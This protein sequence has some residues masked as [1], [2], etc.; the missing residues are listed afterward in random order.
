MSPLSRVILSEKTRKEAGVYLANP[1]HALLVVGSEGDG[2]EKLSNALV[3]EIL[4]IDSLVTL[5]N[6]PRAMVI[7]PNKNGNI[8]IDE[9]REAWKFSKV[10][11]SKGGTK[12]VLIQ[13]AQA[14]TVEAQNSLLKLLEEPPEHMLFVLRVPSTRSV[15]STIDSRT[16][17]LVITGVSKEEFRAVLLRKMHAE[18]KDI[19]KL[20]TTSAGKVY[21]ALSMHNADESKGLGYAKTI[22]TKKGYDRLVETKGLMSDRKKAIELASDLYSLSFIAMN[23]SI[24]SGKEGRAWLRRVKRTELAINNLKAN[25]NVKLNMTNLLLD[26]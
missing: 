21:D 16:S 8:S 13:S 22:M 18:A 23:Q 2:A 3:M 12:V 17:K 1:S 19:E 24:K 11:A 7:S 15:L 14:L 4:D 10:P 9:I 6:T 5:N 25:G 26:I 20:W